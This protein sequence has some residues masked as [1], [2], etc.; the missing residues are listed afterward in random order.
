MST[1]NRPSSSESDVILDDNEY[2]KERIL[3]ITDKYPLW[4]PLSEPVALPEP[5][6]D[7]FVF[8]L[9]TT[10]RS[11][12]SLTSSDSRP[13]LRIPRPKNVTLPITPAK[14]N[15]DM[16]NTSSPDTDSDDL[17]LIAILPSSSSSSSSSTAVAAGSTTSGLIESFIVDTY[18]SEVHNQLR[19]D[20]RKMLLA[21]YTAIYNENINELRFL[22]RI[23][24]DMSLPNRSGI[25]PI[26]YSV[27]HGKYKSFE[28]LLELDRFINHQDV[29]GHTLLMHMILSRSPI[30]YLQHLLDRSPILQ[31]TN[32]A[33]QTA[34][35]LA[36]SLGLYN[37]I[38]ILS[39]DVK[40]PPPACSRMAES[41]RATSHGAAIT[42]KPT[43]L[44]IPPAKRRPI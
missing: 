38:E 22:T 12:S 14:D 37:Y 33:N 23:G 3:H 9:K 4:E 29:C 42:R 25:S 6:T 31:L 10:H 5:N 19:V 43:E 41:P 28:V 44:P 26:M 17:P 32:N 16:D 27:I 40:P 20:K 39:K 21:L 36:K 24:M 30:R 35:D 8:H 13:I 34:L 2:D 1:V 11:D 15:M 7:G 18:P